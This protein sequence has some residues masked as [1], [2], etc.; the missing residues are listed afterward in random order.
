MAL[1]H[2]L[3]PGTETLLPQQIIVTGAGTAAA[4]GVYN[5]TTSTPGSEIWTQVADANYTITHVG[6]TLVFELE[7]VGTGLLY[8]IDSYDGTP[9]ANWPVG[10]G[11]V[12]G[13][14]SGVAPTPVSI[15]TPGL[16][17]SMADPS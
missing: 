1:P 3:D 5:V 14:G 4:N 2:I 11:W 6:P 8:E 9:G 16:P 15:R 13:V 7:V 10:D 17:I 12:I